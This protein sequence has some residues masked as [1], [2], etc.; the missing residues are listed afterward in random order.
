MITKRII[1]FILMIFI[2]T[3]SFCAIHSEATY[4]HSWCK[5]HNG[6]E[7]FKNKDYTRVDCLTSTHAVEFD[8]AKKWAESIGQALH[9]QE[10]SGKRGM[11]VL[12]L[13]NPKK[14]MIYFNRIKKLSVKYDFDVEYITP[15]DLVLI[16]N[17]HP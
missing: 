16:N 17:K 11:I 15:D 14:E 3:Q 2:Q 6:I 7:E 1:V 9:Y 12:I 10:M 13:E 4:R 5:A 8:F